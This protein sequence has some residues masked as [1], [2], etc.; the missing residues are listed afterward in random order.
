MVFTLLLNRDNVLKFFGNERVSDDSIEHHYG[1]RSESKI[2]FL[3]RFQ[4]VAS[5]GVGEE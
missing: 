4:S 1:G 3:C 2:G 5:A